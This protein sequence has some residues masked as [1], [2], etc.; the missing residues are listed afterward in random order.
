VA[1]TP[2]ASGW[3]SRP[4]VPDAV[5]RELLRDAELELVGRM[6]WSSN[7]T[8]LAN[9]GNDDG[10]MLAIYKPRQGERPLWDFRT[11]TLC[12]REVAA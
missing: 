8:F 7:G 5:A 3:P 1:G 4:P 10:E 2:A 12:Q 6:P 11:G 9:L